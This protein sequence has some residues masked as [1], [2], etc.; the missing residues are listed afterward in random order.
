MKA[1]GSACV[2]LDI[3]SPSSDGFLLPH[4]TESHLLFITEMIL[5]GNVLYCCCLQSG[6]HTAQVGFDSTM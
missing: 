3:P 6:S 2:Q 5:K 4:A 1:S